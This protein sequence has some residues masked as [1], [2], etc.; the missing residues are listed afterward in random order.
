MKLPSA[1]ALFFIGLIIFSPTFFNNNSKEIPKIFSELFEKE[2]NIPLDV[3]DA[4]DLI[5]AVIVS[6]AN[7][8]KKEA[9][10]TDNSKQFVIHRLYRLSGEI[11]KFNQRKSSISPSDRKDFERFSNLSIDWLASNYVLF[12]LENGKYPESVIDDSIKGIPLEQLEKKS[13]ELLEL[14]GK[15]DGIDYISKFSEEGSKNVR[16]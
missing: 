12:Y 16:K 13:L 4:Q 2:E 15:N 5:R 10:N 8:L 6:K 3:V 9:E 14:Q 11:S 1:P 7:S